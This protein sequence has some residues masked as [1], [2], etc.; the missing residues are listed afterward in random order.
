MHPAAMG[1]AD[2]IHLYLAEVLTVLTDDAFSAFPRL[3]AEVHL[4]VSNFGNDMATCMRVLLSDLH[5]ETTT[6]SFPAY[7]LQTQ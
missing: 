1:L 2:S 3:G 7:R 6:G 5:N 4:Q